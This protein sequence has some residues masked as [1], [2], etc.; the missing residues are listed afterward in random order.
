MRLLS[1][2]IEELVITLAGEPGMARMA[3]RRFART[4]TRLQ[5]KLALQ[6]ETLPR[7]TAASAQLAHLEA[8]LFIAGAARLAPETAVTFAAVQTQA[9]EAREA[10][11]WTKARIVRDGVPAD[12]CAIIAYDTTPY[13]P[14]LREAATE[15]G[16]PLRFAA[17]EPLARNPATAALLNLLELTIE[18]WA[19]RKLLDAL[20]APYFDLS[21]FSLT[22]PDVDQ[23]D[24]A[25]RYGQ[26]IE[27]LDQWQEALDRLA[28][29]T[30][31]TAAE[32]EDEPTGPQLPS[33]AVALALWQRLLAF[34]RRVTP[35]E[36]ATLTGFVAW[37]EDLMSAKSG[38]GLLERATSRPET[39]DR[40]LSALGILR[41]V[42]RALVLSEQVIGEQAERAFA[43]FYTELRG[44]VEAAAHVPEAEGIRGVGRV[45]AADLSQARGVPY[46]AVV[47]LGLA[48]GLFPAPLTED[49]F[50]A[51][52]ER[53][54]LLAAGLLL[55]PRLRSDQQ[56]LF[57]EAV[58]RASE[59]LLLTRPYLADDG[60]TWEPSPYWNAA[61][62]LFEAKPRRIRLD[63]RL[64]FVEAASA[65]E[66]LASAVRA[67]ALPATFAELRPEWDQ[68][69]HAGS[70]LAAR[71]AR[72]PRGEHEGELVSLVPALAAR[73]GPEH[74]WSASRLEA[75]S[76]CGFQFYISRA[77]GL[78]ERE[79]PSPGY[80][81][82]QLGSM[83]HE[84]LEEVYQRAAD[85]LDIETVVAA[86]PAVARELFDSAPE[87]FGFRATALWE[88]ERAELI[89]KL[90]A[91]LRALADEPG[92]YRPVALEARFG[93]QGKPLASLET[94]VG[95]V[96]YHGV[97]DRV[98]QDEQ[99]QLRIIDYKSGSSGLS[100]ADL[101]QGRRLQLP[102]YAHAAEAALHLGPVAEGFYWKIRQ[103]KAGSLRLSR[104]QTKSDGA[105]RGP[106]GA[107]RL[108]AN[109]VADYVRG[110]RA[111]EFQP[112]APD[113]G[114]PVYCPARLF[115]WRYTPGY[116]A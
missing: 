37:I 38:L 104:F 16:V 34:A 100:P 45:Y 32:P 83:L 89:E 69:R 54:S 24:E 17:G 9:L 6:V 31:T 111:G 105:L 50:L 15:F 13:Q 76:S 86:L 27:G 60:E 41:E 57:Y 51:D 23:L 94:S 4:L 2:Q 116:G 79:T 106:G 20:R 63:D 98:D 97:I 91:T 42:L 21:A 110:I 80:D 107:I 115:C 56:T 49:P 102:L 95:P 33:G 113:G 64:P 48:E 10:L 29:R 18:N 22:A 3:H 43:D 11:R 96:L 65:G 59:Y 68:L 26:V 66:L 61:L 92:R 75:Y 53:E 39:A 52:E 73:F 93:L 67:R 103:A 12:K 1:L 90:E 84:I 14:F 112:V 88:A 28:R 58:T 74:V 85:T 46:R 101:E 78:E 35:P 108:V 47:V 36:T 81:A 99:G 25:A 77:L 5:V 44:A 87:R 82:A 70:V 55:E 7:S 19:R 8:G 30:E 72:Q 62:G 109:Y 71:V 40:D 114:C